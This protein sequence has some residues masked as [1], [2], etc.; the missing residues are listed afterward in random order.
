MIAIELTL[1][2]WVLFLYQNELK[3]S[4][5]VL[6]IS[7][8]LNFQGFKQYQWLP[9]RQESKDYRRGG[10]SS[11]FAGY[12]YWTA[13]AD[14]FNFKCSH[15]SCCI[16]SKNQDWT[17]KMIVFPNWS[18]SRLLMGKMEYDL[19]SAWICLNGL[20]FIWQKIKALRINLLP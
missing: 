5:R 13:N 20:K 17:N 1:S 2:I 14:D 6:Y 12:L 10:T 3:K 8:N 16:L 11:G 4:Y 15:I 18:D 9:P 19:I 7:L